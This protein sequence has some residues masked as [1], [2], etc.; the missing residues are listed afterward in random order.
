METNLVG[1]FITIYHEIT[2]II[3]L[4]SNSEQMS[5]HVLIKK[6]HLIEPAWAERVLSEF[7]LFESISGPIA[8]YR[9]L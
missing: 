2:Y 5:L 6:M 8:W 1:N 3:N 9:K 7:V 4:E